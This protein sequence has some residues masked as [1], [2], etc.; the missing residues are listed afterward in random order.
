MKELYFCRG[1]DLV[2]LVCYLLLDPVKEFSVSERIK[3]FSPFLSFLWPCWY[4]WC[5]FRMMASLMSNRTSSL[6][7]LLLTQWSKTKSAMSSSLKIKKLFLE[8]LL[9]PF[10]SLT[11]WLPRLTKLLLWS[12]SFSIPKWSEAIKLPHGVWTTCFHHL[13][14]LL[15]TWPTFNQTRLKMFFTSQI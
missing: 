12:T 11:F 3:D 13:R 4:W 5:F 7:I 14:R 8:Y 15:Q 9:V 10:C 2:S 1:Q 6:T